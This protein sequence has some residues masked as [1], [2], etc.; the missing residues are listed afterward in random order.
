[1]RDIAQRS[2]G[3]SQDW[4]RLNSRLPNHAG[5]PE[6]LHALMLRTAQDALLRPAAE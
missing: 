6:P 2:G 3:A 1:M 5:S 4:D